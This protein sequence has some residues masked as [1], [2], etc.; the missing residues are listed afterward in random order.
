M[1]L[2]FA[3]SMGWYLN[4]FRDSSPAAIT[5]Q[6]R[7]P[8]TS[9]T[10]DRIENH[11]TEWDLAP[12]F[13]LLTL[14]DSERICVGPIWIQHEASRRYRKPVNRQIRIHLASFDQEV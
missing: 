6:G 5:T 11:D 13:E 14:Y 3:I 8:K 7:A 10:K 9:N 12:S 1:T 2:S 4:K